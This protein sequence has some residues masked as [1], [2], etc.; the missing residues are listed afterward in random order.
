MALDPSAASQDLAALGLAWLR[1]MPTVV[2]VPAFG[3]RALPV[4]ARGVLGLALAAGIYPALI[5]AL[6]AEQ[7]LPW[8]VIAF[9]QLL[10]GLPIALAAAIP[11]WAATMAGG[12]VDVLRGSPDATEFATNEGRASRFGIL[13]SLLASSVFL[14]TGGAARAA[15]ALASSTLP[16]NPLVRATHDIVGGVSLAV[17]I[18]GPLLASAVVLEVAFALLARAAH[19]AQVPALLSPLRALGVLAV[20]A[21]TLERI[22]AL[23]AASVRAPLP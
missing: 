15:S 2:V 6:N 5:P 16:G 9:E 11:L 4:P 22:A 23:I 20:V 1:V 3:L 7:G 12:L 17:A 14:T 19:P 18:G 13:L 8:L 21:V 10:L